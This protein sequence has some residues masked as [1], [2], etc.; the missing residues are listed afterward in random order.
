MR[1][2]VL[3]TTAMQ[4]TEYRLGEPLEEYLRRRYNEDGVTLAV[5]AAEIGI[6]VSTASRWMA[7]L[8]IEARFPGQR[9]KASEVVAS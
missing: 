9:G 8:G 6:N 4:R 3:K 7:Q 1:E 2:Q 5:I